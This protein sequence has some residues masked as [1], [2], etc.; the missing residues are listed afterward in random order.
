M[1][2]TSTLH[3]FC[4]YHYK[5]RNQ[6]LRFKGIVVSAVTDAAEVIIVVAIVVAVVFGAVDVIVHVPVNVFKGED[7]A[8]A[9]H[10]FRI[11]QNNFDC[12]SLQ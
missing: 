3:Y 1:R 11:P 10:V 12:V 5:Q 8:V 9:V 4:Y 7:P 6:K 2:L